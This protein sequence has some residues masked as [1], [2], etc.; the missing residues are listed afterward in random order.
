MNIQ[1]VAKNPKILTCKISLKHLHG[2]DVY[3][4]L[5][6][7]ANGKL[8]RGF[9]KDYGDNCRSKAIGEWLAEVLQEDLKK[10]AHRAEW[11][12]VIGRYDSHIED[13]TIKGLRYTVMNGKVS[14]E[15]R[16]GMKAIANIL[17]NINY[18]MKLTRGH[19]FD[20]LEVVKC[21]F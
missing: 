1:V 5:G 11:V 9:C 19:E 16:I 21:T 12:N 18:S 13:G 4:A 6:K 3:V 14:I 15:E 20:V 8:Q 2:K 10:I 17:M 7:D